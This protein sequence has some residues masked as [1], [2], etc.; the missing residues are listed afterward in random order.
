MNMDKVD[1][2]KVDVDKVD[3]D[4]MNMDE[5]VNSCINTDSIMWNVTPSNSIQPDNDI[6]GGNHTTTVKLFDFLTENELRISEYVNTIPYNQLYYHCIC[7]HEF[8][9]I[10][11][12]RENALE[13]VYVE[14]DKKYLLCKYIRY[15]GVDFDDFMFCLPTPKLVIFHALDSY[16]HLLVSLHKLNQIGVCYYNFSPDKLSF[17]EYYKPKLRSFERSIAINDVNETFLTNLI[18]NTSDFTHKP[19]EVHVLFYLSRTNTLNE[20]L[21]ETICDKFIDNMG[22]LRLFSQSYKDLHKNECISF[23]TSY[24]GKPRSVIIADM[25]KYIETWDNYSLSLLYLHLI[26]NIT[27]VFSLKGT[28]MSKLIALLT[29]NISP[30][31]EKRE[32]ISNT[33][34]YYE[35]LYYDFKDWSFVDEIPINKIDKLHEMLLK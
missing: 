10:G 4:K 31:P 14:I 33:K 17:D 30:N 8:I 15:K 28:I 9:K 27:S 25:L 35:R 18:A 6:T 16:S 1:M 2:D 7:E 32:K 21:I 22:V 24:I 13:D 19:L 5:N 26:G 20:S 12:L 23:L 29:K 34:L 11:Q 3:V